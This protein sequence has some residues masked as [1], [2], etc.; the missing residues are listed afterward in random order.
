MRTPAQNKPE[1]KAFQ[2]KGDSS[3]KGIV[4]SSNFRG[5]NRGGYGG[6]G[7]G[8]CRGGGRSESDERQN[9]NPIQWRNCNNGCSN[10]MCGARSMF[11]ELDESQRKE[12]TLGNDWK[13][14]VE[15]KV[16]LQL[17]PHNVIGHSILFDDSC[18][19]KDKKSGKIVANM[20]QNRIFPLDISTVESFDLVAGASVKNIW[21]LRYGHLSING[22]QF[23]EHK[24]MIIG[25][26]KIDTIDFCEDC[27]YGNQSRPS[28]PIRYSM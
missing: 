5:N 7:R 24:G 25:L 21:H 22:L 10:H 19:I 27:V 18:V 23:L 3:S 11:K 4:E 1:E 12:V 13:M 8:R 15:G 26:P 16:I 2:V 20:T 14:K 9:R 28:F 6:R 17:K